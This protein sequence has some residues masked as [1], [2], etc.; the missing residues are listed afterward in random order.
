PLLR[1]GPRRRPRHGGARP[2]RGRKARLPG[3]AV[4]LRRQH[5]HAG[6]EAVAGPG[7]RRGR[8]GAPGG[9]APP[10]PPCR[11][12]PPSP[13]PWAR[14]LL[15]PLL[16]LELVDVLLRVLVEGVL[17]ARAAHVERLAHVRDRHRAAPARNDTLRALLRLRQALADLRARQGELRLPD[18][19]AV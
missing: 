19:A 7:P 8:H 3:H 2:G 10:A 17:A 14:G 1:P 18:R 5:Q 13:P 6:G 12:G 4:Q 16:R 9:P 15:L 11:T